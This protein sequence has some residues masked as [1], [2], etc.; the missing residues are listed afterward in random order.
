[1]KNIEHYPGGIS[2]IS[3]KQNLQGFEKFV[4]SWLIRRDHTF[5]VDAGTSFSA[6][7]LAASLKELGVM[8][9]DA[10][11]ITHIHIDHAGG[12][13]KLLE[14][15]PGT[16]VV[17]H[18]SGIPHL[19]N[20]EKLWKGSLKTLG[21]FAEAYGPIFPVSENLLRDAASFSDLPITAVMTPGHAPHHVSYLYDEILFAGEAAGVFIEL[22]D[23]KYYQRPA[24]PPKFF[25]ETTL[26]SLKKIRAVPHEKI[27]FAHFGMTSDTPGVLLR[28][29]EQLLRWSEIIGGLSGYD[30]P[31]FYKKAADI[32]LEKD[33]LMTALKE[34]EP[35]D[36]ER[37]KGFLKNS[38]L[39]YA[40]YFRG[41]ASAG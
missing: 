23:G 30:D 33:P 12:L 3:L 10:I 38:I 7:L 19:V 8:K 28:A 39:G 41:R 40:G 5:I 24:T 11:L 34:M 22:K 21:H 26:E 2:L 14:Y 25:L 31:D 20:P 35:D 29:E 4:N 18:S 37:E 27:C 32:L 1:M 36:A 6:P 17:M 15:Y 16:P 9:L 13:G